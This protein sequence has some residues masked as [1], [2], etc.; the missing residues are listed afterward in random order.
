MMLKDQQTG[1]EKIQKLPDKVETL[2]LDH[3]HQDQKQKTLVVLVVDRLQEGA[4]DHLQEEVVLHHL[5]EV[6]H[7]VVAQN[8]EIVEALQET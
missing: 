5:E 4:V 2:I 7:Q 3:H 8:L 6:D 1:K